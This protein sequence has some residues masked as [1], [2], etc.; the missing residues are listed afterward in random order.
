MFYRFRLRRLRGEWVGKARSPTRARST[1][2]RNRSLAEYARP[3]PRLSIDIAH[4]P[5]TLPQDRSPVHG[6]L[7]YPSKLTIDSE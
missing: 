6:S 7:S 3:I 4:F 5:L 2:A 1:D